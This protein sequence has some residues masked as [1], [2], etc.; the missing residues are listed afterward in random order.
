MYDNF[1]EKY[2]NRVF[3]TLEICNEFSNFA[4][5]PWVVRLFGNKVIFR[6]LVKMNIQIHSST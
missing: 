4:N 2:K 1:Q 6:Q 3:Q 5:P